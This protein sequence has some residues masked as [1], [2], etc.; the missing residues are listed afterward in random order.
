MAIV[1]AFV[2]GSIATAAPLR[3]EAVRLDSV[4]VQIEDPASG[5]SRMFHL[6]RHGELL[7]YSPGKL[8]QVWQFSEKEAR[9]LL[10]GF[11]RDGCLRPKLRRTGH[12]PTYTVLAVSNGRNVLAV[13]TKDLPDRL[14]EF[15]KTAIPQE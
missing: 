4:E 13:S 7:Y 11:V 9:E 14:V 15:C 8:Q 2:G 1:T 10:D 6:S 3:P 12:G 5:K